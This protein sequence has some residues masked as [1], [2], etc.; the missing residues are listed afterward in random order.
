MKSKSVNV[1]QLQ[2]QPV[3]NTMV[4]SSIDEMTDLAS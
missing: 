3:E 2:I 4:N 1:E